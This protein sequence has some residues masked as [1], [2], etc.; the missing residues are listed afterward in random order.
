MF[1][2]ARGGRPDPRL[3]RLASLLHVLAAQSREQRGAAG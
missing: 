1:P 3:D 2:A